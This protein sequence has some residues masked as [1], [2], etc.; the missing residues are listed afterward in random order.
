[1]F[2]DLYSKES[3]LWRQMGELCANM[4]SA[5]QTGFDY[6]SAPAK[7]ARFNADLQFTSKTAMDASPLVFA[8]LISNT[9][10]QHGHMSQLTITKTQRARLV[11][12][13]DSYFKKQDG[14]LDYEASAAVIVKN[15]LTKKGYRASDEH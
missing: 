8:A 3:D 4:L 9:P 6:S 15:Y 12:S 7:M 2:A 5:P 14:D 13:V 10:D 1:M 11:S